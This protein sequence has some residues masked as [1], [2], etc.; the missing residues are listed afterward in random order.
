MTV[1]ENPFSTLTNL[2]CASVGSEI[3]FATDDFFAVA[4]NFL[5]PDPPIFDINA[6]TEFG[7]EM[8]GWETRRKRTAGHDWCIIKLGL[9]GTI[10]G[11]EVDTGYFTG[12]QVP[13][14]SIQA[15]TLAKQL[16]LKRRCEMGSSCTEA[17]LKAAEAVG[18]DKWEELVPYTPLAPGYEESR[19]HY[20]RLPDSKQRYTHLRVNLY[21]DGGIA[22]FRT[23]G[24]VSKDWSVVPND[25]IVDLA[26][27]ENG[28]RAV[29]FSNAH[30]GHPRNLIAFGRSKTMAGGWETARN[31]ERPRVYVP[32]PQTKQL[33]MPG[34][35]WAI[36]SLGHTGKVSEVE[37]DTHLFKGNFPESAIVEGAYIAPADSVQ[38]ESNS[39]EI[40][41]FPLVQRTKLGPHA[42][43]RFAVDEKSKNNKVSHVRV[44]MFPDGGIARLRILG[45]LSV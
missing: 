9:P 43:V 8:D 15:A 31:P 14:V 35:D 39:S 29:S 44:T 23:F 38:A 26:H 5:K 41:W 28:G 33:V 16:P 32:D 2:S 40:Q 13:G 42:Q 3:L 27:V 7:K 19:Y 22:R 17:E 30:Y 1:Q 4:E 24:L 36:I 21:P 11:F 18:S 12:N 25:Q 45:T 34:K 6:F 37:I 10:E 20:I